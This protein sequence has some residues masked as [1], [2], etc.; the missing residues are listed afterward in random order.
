MQCSHRGAFLDMEDRPPPI[1]AEKGTGVKEEEEK[2]G[3]NL[4]V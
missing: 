2:Q 1:R 3:P 4:F